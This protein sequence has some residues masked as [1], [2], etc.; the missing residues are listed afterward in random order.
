MNLKVTTLSNL[1]RRCKRTY[2]SKH[3]FVDSLRAQADDSV[4]VRV[5]TSLCIT[6]VHYMVTCGVVLTDGTPIRKL[7]L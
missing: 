2:N 6:L 3:C 5:R 4:T 1:E 7:I